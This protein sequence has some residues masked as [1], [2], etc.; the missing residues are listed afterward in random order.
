MDGRTRGL[1]GGLEKEQESSKPATFIA[2]AVE[3]AKLGITERG[4]EGYQRQAG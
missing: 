1:L 3:A 4:R 2:D